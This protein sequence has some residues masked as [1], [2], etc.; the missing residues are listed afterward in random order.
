[1]KSSYPEQLAEWVKRR[2]S[3]KRAS[4]VVA[5]L[6]VREDVVAAIDAGYPVKTIWMEMRESQCVNVSYDT[7]LAYVSRYIYGSANSAKAAKSS[8]S[9]AAKVKKGVTIPVA[10]KR[11]IQTASSPIGGFTFNPDP[12]KEDLI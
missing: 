6:A 11:T 3:S 10:G 7:F 12:K 2:R 4:P 8:K 1:M 5:F 9:A